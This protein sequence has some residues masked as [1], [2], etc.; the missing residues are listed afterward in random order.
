MNRRTASILLAACLAVVGGCRPGGVTRYDVSGT[1]TFAGEPVRVGTITFVPTKGNT[2][3]GGSAAI[4]DGRF[5]TATGQRGP[6]GGPHTAVITGFDGKVVPGLEVQE[7]VMLFNE[8]RVEV[9]LPKQAVVRDFE[10]P[11]SAKVKP[12]PPPPPGRK[13]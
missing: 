8:Y 11:A 13:A 1:V 7:G 12:T 4:R 10:V 6:T 2:G 3:P 5:D 9:D